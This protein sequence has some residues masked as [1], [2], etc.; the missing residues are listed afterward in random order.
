M[1]DAALYA[2]T[3]ESAA[4]GY[5]KVGDDF[6]LKL[7]VHVEKTKR[8]IVRDE[9]DVAPVQVKEGN[10]DVVDHFQYL[11]SKISRNGEVTAEI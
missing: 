2:T 1:D 7:S 8:M 3:F 11:G 4:E 6:G 5:E 9:V 10:L